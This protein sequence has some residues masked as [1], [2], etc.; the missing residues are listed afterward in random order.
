MSKHNKAIPPETVDE[1][2]ADP[3]KKLSILQDAQLLEN[4]TDDTDQ[5]STEIIAETKSDER[6]VYENGVFESRSNGLYYVHLNKN[7]SSKPSTEHAVFICSPIEVIAKTRDAHSTSWGVLIRWFDADGVMHQHSIAIDSFLGDTREYRKYLASKG[8][9]ITPNAKHRHYL[10]IYLQQPIKTR[11][12]LVNNLGWNDEQYVLHNSSLGVNNDEI[13]VYQSSTNISKAP[14]QRGTLV[15]WRDEIC[16]PIAEQSRLVFSLCCAFSGQLLEPLGFD[17]GGFHLLG[18]SSIGKSITMCLAASIWG[19]PRQIVRSWR[20]TDNALEGT[21]REHNDSILLLDEIGQLE[22]NIAV[23]TAYMLANGV[24]KSRS[25]VSGTNQKSHTWRLIFLSNGEQSIKQHVAYESKEVTAGVEVRVAHIEADAGFGHGIFDSLVMADSGAAQADKIKELVSHYH[26]TAGIAW[27][28]Y[29]TTDKAETTAKA[30]SLIKKFM[31]QYN[32]LSSQP[33]RVAKRFAL[34]AA[35]GE[36]A[37]LAGITGWQ[38]GQATSAVK[39]CLHNWLDNYGRDSEHED[40][41]IINNVKAFIE[42]HGSSR[43]QPCYEKRSAVFEDKISNRSG[44]HNR[45][46]NEFYFY[47][48]N[49]EK[50][51]CSPFSKR[52][53]LQVLMNAELLDTS[54][55]EPGRMAYKL[56]QSCIKHRPRVYVIKG[57]ILSYEP[58]KSTNIN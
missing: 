29:I 8:L 20:Q 38:E 39:V 5:P 53:V 15:Q 35:A 1:Q 34:V 56:P 6:F 11:A 24:S 26:G 32:D 31:L 17:G 23:K 12:L 42:K 4:N 50:D 7:K 30:N 47:T 2:S 14:S 43:F 25:S 57:D 51:V 49:F 40:R 21:A 16:R 9:T 55:N 37:T 19:N 41:Q 13:I 22:S 10:D 18:S 46:T 36:M 58:N 3:I 48:S 33:H 54:K 52:K 28:E 27:L 45:D 44:Y